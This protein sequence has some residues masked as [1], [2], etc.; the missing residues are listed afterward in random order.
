VYDADRDLKD[1]TWEDIN[2]IVVVYKCYGCYYRHYEHIHKERMELDP[3]WL[4]LMIGPLLT[5]Y[6]K[7][8]ADHPFGRQKRKYAQTTLDTAVSLKKTK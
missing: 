1:I 6:T 2:N 7:W 3:Q 5:R 8:L 4:D